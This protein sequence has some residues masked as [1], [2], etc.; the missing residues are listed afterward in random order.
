MSNVY[1][2]RHIGLL[3]ALHHLPR[4]DVGHPRPAQGGQQG[5]LRQDDD[6]GAHRL[7]HIPHHPMRP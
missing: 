4:G 5:D 7:L 2:S 3:V 1:V 6:Q